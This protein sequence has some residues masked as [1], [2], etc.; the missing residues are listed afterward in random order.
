MLHSLT[1]VRVFVL[2]IL[3]TPRVVKIEKKKEK[4]AKLSTGKQWG[5]DVF[6]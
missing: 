4:K 1:A 3:C 6:S 2:T 5:K